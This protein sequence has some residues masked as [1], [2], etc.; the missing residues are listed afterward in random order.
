MRKDLENIQVALGGETSFDIY[1]TGWDKTFALKF[2]PNSNIYFV[3]DRCE[4]SGNDFAI[5]KACGAR[6][7]S[8][9]G[10][11][12]TADIIEKILAENEKK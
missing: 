6:G 4:Q 12:E 8:T 7:Y 11:S 2:F 1:P 9:T 3:G 10:P 5:Y